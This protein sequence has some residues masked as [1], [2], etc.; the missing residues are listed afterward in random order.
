MIRKVFEVAVGTSLP[1]PGVPRAEGRERKQVYFLLNLVPNLGKFHPLITAYPSVAVTVV[2][3]KP[4]LLHCGENDH[5][6]AW[7]RFE[8]VQQQVVLPVLQALGTVKQRG[9]C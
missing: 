3:S 6:F 2:L 9:I 4:V 5:G 1:S 8:F 7:Q